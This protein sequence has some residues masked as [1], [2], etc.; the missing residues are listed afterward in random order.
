[1]T[2][3]AAPELGSWK[4][5]HAPEMP[6]RLGVSTCLL[7]ENVRFDGGHA[8]DRF[9]T[10]TLGQLFEWVSVCP[11]VEIGM[12]TPRPTIRL[13]DDGDGVRL[14]APSTEEDFTDRMHAFSDAKIAELREL[15]L[16]GYILKKSSPSCG[17]ERIKVYKNGMPSRRDERGVFV[18]RLLTAW[19]T[20]P[21]EE[22]GR[23]NDPRLRENF[24]ERVFSRNRWRVL[25][26]RGL[27]RRSLVE[28]H[29][30]HKLLIRAHDEAAY[31]RL[32]KLVGS[33]GTIS[34]EDLFA[35]YELEFQ[36]ALAV[37]V[38]AKKHVNVLQHALGYLK[39]I[40]DPLE[41]REILAAIE[42]Y[43]LGMLP[44]VVPLTL[45]RYNIR[46]HGIE[47]LAGQVYFDPHPRELMLRNHV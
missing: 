24:I 35:A 6:L 34:D 13:V 33:A 22:D 23:L 3:K 5:W 41:K 1:M 19:P 4:N 30:A 42:D 31:T 2:T 47:Y 45:L 14:V 43:R 39:T 10:D 28:F 26:S 38:T 37:K 44:L 21:V 18:E 29:T 11:E 17:L 36:H 27:T 9:V 20:L 7:G 15:D 25:V 16:D 8:R 32:G 12:G 46:R 40:L